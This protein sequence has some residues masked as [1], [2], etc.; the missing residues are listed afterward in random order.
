MNLRAKMGDDVVTDIQS[1]WT[2]RNRK[3]ETRKDYEKDIEASNKLI[4]QKLKELLTPVTKY[5]SFLL[6]I[7][8][9]SMELSQSYAIRKIGGNCPATA[10]RFSV[11]LPSLKEMWATK[12]QIEIFP[13]KIERALRLLKKTYRTNHR[14]HRMENG[15]SNVF[16]ILFETST[17]YSF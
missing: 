4:S 6:T 2:E 7:N 5:G 14:G 9:S 17:K 11:M 13:W 8:D 1:L 16:L 15:N 3:V 10:V 12:K